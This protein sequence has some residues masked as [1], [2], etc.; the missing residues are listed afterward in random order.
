M[1]QRCEDHIVPT[2]LFPPAVA[3]RR[4]AASARYRFA[5]RL[6]PR[7]DR[8]WRWPN[9]WCGA[10]RE[11]ERGPLDPSAQPRAADHRSSSDSGV[12]AIEAAGFRGRTDGVA[13]RLGHYRVVFIPDSLSQEKK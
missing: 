2:G 5:A 7:R 6:P 1:V 9:R 3:V 12:N 10:K 8:G 4:L 13:L 11:K